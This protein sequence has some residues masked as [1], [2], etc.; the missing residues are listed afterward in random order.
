MWCVRSQ[1]R[2]ILRVRNRSEEKRES[3]DRQGDIRLVA[4]LGSQVQQQQTEAAGTWAAVQRISAS[5]RAT[6]LELGRD[7]RGTTDDG[8]E[9]TFRAELTDW[10]SERH[11]WPWGT[12]VL[13]PLCYSCA[14]VVLIV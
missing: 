9:T 7:D 4:V 1:K 6:Q 5:H 11:F 2:A 10:D 3:R 12:C 14:G 13:R 8:A